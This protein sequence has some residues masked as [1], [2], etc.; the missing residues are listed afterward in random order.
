M[1]TEFEATFIDINKNKLRKKLEEAGAKLLQPEI[2]MRRVIFDLGPKRFVRVRDEGD[3]ITMSYKQVD[4]LTLNG[5][6]EICVNVSNYEDAIELLKH[7][8]LEPK[9]NQETLRETWELDKVEITI[10]TWPWLPTYVEIEGKNAES[11]IKVAEKLGFIM[12]DAHYGSVNEIYK[13]YYDVTDRDINYCPVI[14]FI[15]I[16][17]WLEKKRR[18]GV[19]F[20]I[21]DSEENLNY[22]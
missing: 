12:S 16:P 20:G 3:N 2:L 14:K 22:N 10:D 18:P 17:E 5:T 7:A 19:E 13:I 11:T 15:E 9:A 1:P 4:N 6:K 21:V 8:G